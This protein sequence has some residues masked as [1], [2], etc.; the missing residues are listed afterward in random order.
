MKWPVTPTS[1]RTLSVISRPRRWW[2]SWLRTVSTSAADNT[3]GGSVT[4]AAPVTAAAAT[5]TTT[6]ACR[7][8][9]SSLI[10]A[11]SGL[12]RTSANVV[13]A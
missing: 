12:P 5:V 3:I 11:V 2:R 9:H 13:P 6:T 4:Q 8:P 1:V 7:Q 10:A